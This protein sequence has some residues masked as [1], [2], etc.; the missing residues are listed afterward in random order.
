MRIK[1]LREEHKISQ[2][3]LAKAIGSTVEELERWENGSEEP[4]I[5][6]SLALA[7]YFNCDVYYLLGKEAPTHTP[8]DDIPLR[9]IKCPRCRSKNLAFVT[10]YHKALGARII[11]MVL[12]VILIILLFLSI[13]DPGDYT[14][15]SIVLLITIAILQV[16]IVATESSTNVQCI[17]KDCGK[18]WLHD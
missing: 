15:F 1:D 14:T 18:T 9:P 8:S 10:E 4:P 13:Q 6:Y 17:C 7:E 16:Y 12:G 11:Q 2:E 3:E 5:A